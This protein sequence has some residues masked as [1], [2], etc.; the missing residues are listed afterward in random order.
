VI[1]EQA[2]NE[3][4]I[5][6]DQFAIAADALKNVFAMM[7]HE[8]QIER[9]NVATGIALTGGSTANCLLLI[10]ESRIGGF[11]QFEQRFATLQFL[12]GRVCKDRIAFK[13]G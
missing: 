11:D 6:A 13:F 7:R 12:F 4:D 2:V 10:L 8:F 5:V 3:D 1:F 9:R